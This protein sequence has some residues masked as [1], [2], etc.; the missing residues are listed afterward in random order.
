MVGYSGDYSIIYA[1]SS[2]H[3]CMSASSSEPVNTTTRFIDTLPDVSA[4]SSATTSVG[5]YMYVN[6]TDYPVSDNYFLRLKFQPDAWV[7]C[8][9]SGALYD[10]LETCTGD[11]AMSDPFEVDIS[12]EY[13]GSYFWATT[14]SHFGTYGKWNGVYE[15][16]K[17]GIL[18]LYS[19][20]IISTSTQFI[21]GTTSPMDLVR[22]NIASTTAAQYSE[23]KSAIMSI[24]ASTTANL[25]QVCTP[26]L[27][28]GDFSLGDCLVLIF[29]PGSN[30]LQ[31]DISLIFTIPPV[32]YAY[33]FFN[34]FTDTEATSSLPSLSYT[35]ASSSAF[36]MVGTVS[37]DPFGAVLD[38]GSIVSQAK[39]DR[40]DQKNVWDIFEPVIRLIVY[41]TLG[42]IIIRDLTGIHKQ[43]IS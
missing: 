23:N 38:A 28:G 3:T 42:F 11:F 14:T 10:A 26:D 29:Y 4:T 1:T 41:L 39:S 16:R 13:F 25:K 24:L 12:D 8:T 18:G 9:Q 17:K 30:A 19:T 31:D 21:V 34:I 5:V 40:D 32:S 2:S 33:R 20:L 35:F 36:S 22:E 15:F 43:D 6:S 7:A 37:F 27:W